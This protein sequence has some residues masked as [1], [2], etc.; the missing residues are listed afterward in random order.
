MI[1]RFEGKYEFLSNFYPSEIEYEGVVY[2]TVEHAFQAAKTLD[3]NEREE[4]A[5][6]ATPSLAKKAG[7]S[8]KLRSDWENVKDEVMLACLRTKFSIPELREKLVA[9][10]DEWLIEGNTWH[11]NYWGD[12]SCPKCAGIKGKNT[13]GYLLC[14]VRREILEE[15]EEIMV[16]V[17][18]QEDFVNGVL[19]N[20]E[21]KAVVP[22]VVEVVKEHRAEKKQVVFTYDTH[23]RDTYADSQEGRNL[24]VPHCFKGEAGW[25]IVKELRPYVANTICFE[26]PT[27]GS[28]ELAQWL[29]AKAKECATKG[30]KL[31]IKLVGVCTDICVISNALLIK[32]FLPEVQVIVYAKCCA[33]VTPEKHNAALEAMR[34]CQVTVIE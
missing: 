26:K 3:I 27:F 23:N 10:G 16:V 1:E 7:R 4:I 9:T 12:C 28:T 29:V 22:A 32:A 30:K 8:V 33:G 21:T 25:E 14:V 31:V 34:S 15:T 19:G 17:D 6:L 24:P 2:P 18:M 11:D 20:N 5:K 13:L